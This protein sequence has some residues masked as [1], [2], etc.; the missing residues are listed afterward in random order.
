[1]VDVR[2]EARLDAVNF[3][4]CSSSSLVVQELVLTAID[5]YPIL[6]CDFMLVVATRSMRF[7]SSLRV[8]L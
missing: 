2:L 5:L 7:G 6:A 3:L 4:F 8:L 1:M